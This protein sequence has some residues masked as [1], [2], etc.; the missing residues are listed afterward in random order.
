M[1]PV[2]EP[3]RWEERKEISASIWD[4][5]REL[6][7]AKEIRVAKRRLMYT[8]K[9][10]NEKKPAGRPFQILISRRTAW[11]LEIMKRLETRDEHDK[12]IRV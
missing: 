2:K 10:I 1:L 6:R 12:P 9:N 3:G 8:K 5:H 7:V 4:Y 11:W